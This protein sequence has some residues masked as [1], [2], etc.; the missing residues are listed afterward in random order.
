VVSRNSLPEKGATP[1]PKPLMLYTAEV[2]ANRYIYIGK[3]PFQVSF[4]QRIETVDG[5]P[6]PIA[7]IPHT[8][9]Q[10]SGDF[11]LV[12]CAN[13]ITLGGAEI[14]SLVAPVFYQDNRANTLF[15]E[16]TF[17]EQTIEEW[18]EWVTRTPEP[19]VEWDLP[20]WWEEMLLEPI[21]PRYNP[22]KPVDPGDPVWR[23]EIDARARFA[24]KGKQDWLTNPAT[25]VQFEGELV[26]PKGRA[27]LAVLPAAALASA[28]PVNVNA[29]SAVA[30]GSAV[31]VI[32]QDA[33]KL[34]GLA[35]AKAGINVI[36]GSGLNSA[37]MKN[38]N[39]LNADL[40][41]GKLNGG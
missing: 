38:M 18:Q 37:L 41:A 26:G 14:G 9:L 6:P 7:R 5:K 22:P 34:A 23:E 10:D 28:T 2:Q 1:L 29:G 3:G 31:V 12:P 36:G 13:A 39:A 8:I 19:E 30:P 35:P 16:P 4:V 32:E 11:T 27:G 33:F 17:K 21:F 15:I 40:D 20:K 24:L 25:V